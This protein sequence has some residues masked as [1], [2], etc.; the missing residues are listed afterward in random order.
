MAVTQTLKTFSAFKFGFW[1][2][3]RFRFMFQVNAKNKKKNNN[4]LLFFFFSAP[5]RGNGFGV[6][7]GFAF[8][9]GFW[10][11]LRFRFMF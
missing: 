11:D 9:F 2:D 10:E 8:K 6:G 5:T 7:F 1:E 4:N 3:L